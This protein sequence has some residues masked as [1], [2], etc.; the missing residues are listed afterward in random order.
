MT[1]KDKQNTSGCGLMLLCAVTLGTLMFVWG[2]LEES[3][4][5]Y[6]GYVVMPAMIMALPAFGWIHFRN[7]LEYKSTAGDKRIT[8]GLAKVA[9][10]VAAMALAIAL[11]YAI[12]VILGKV[13]G[14]GGRDLH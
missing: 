13:I 2:A 10:F 6:A 3:G 8:S 9:R 12:A 11:A 1:G 5:R 4:N 14:I 7:S